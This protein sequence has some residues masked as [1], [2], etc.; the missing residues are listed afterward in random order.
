MSLTETF[1]GYCEFLTTIGVPLNLRPP[2]PAE[3]LEL[4]VRTTRRDDPTGAGRVV[5]PAR[6]TVAG[7]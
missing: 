3:E 1:H 2:A 5:E 4:L 6:S 7:T